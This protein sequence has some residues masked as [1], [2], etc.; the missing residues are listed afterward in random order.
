MYFFQYKIRSVRKVLRRVEKGMTEGSG[1]IFIFPFD[2]PM[3]RG[4]M[5]N[6][7]SNCVHTLA[8]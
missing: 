7:C 1:H 2:V 4:N 6:H 5:D 8:L 3:Q